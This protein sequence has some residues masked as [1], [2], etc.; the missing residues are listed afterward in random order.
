[1]KIRYCVTTLNQLEWL[2]D[3]HL[4][5]VPQEV[6]HGFHLHVS[7]SSE[8]VYNNQKVGDIYNVAPFLFFID[9]A[10]VSVRVSQS[11]NNLGVAPSWNFFVRSAIEDGYDAVII[12]NDDIILYDGALERFTAELGRSPFVC[13]DEH[14]M[15]SFFGMHV[16]LFSNVGE[17]D[18]NFWP[19]YYEDNDYHYRMKLAGV[20]ESAVPPPSYHHQGSATVY[21]F[22]SERKLMHHHNFR[23]NTT[24]YV[25]KWGGLPHAEAYTSPF[26]DAKDYGHVAHQSRNEQL[27]RDFQTFA[28]SG[29]EM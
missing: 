14:S 21:T 27:E 17:F 4:P 16:S 26:G 3:R 13:F 9:S 2:I 8:Q 24:Y 25:T 22:N 6:I 12:A 19:A 28:R 29:E 1:M 20:K 7:E 23:K 11:E 10:D 18:E 5:S 15:F